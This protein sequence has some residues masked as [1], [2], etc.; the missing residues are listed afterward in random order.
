[1][2]STSKYIQLDQQ[3]LLEY[4]YTDPINPLKI[5]TDNN[6]AKILILNN[7]Y[8][9]SSA[10]F[11]EDLP[12]I[13]TGNYRR[14]SVIPINKDRTKYAYLTD[15]NVVNYLDADNNLESVDG[16]LNQLNTYPNVPKIEPEYD[17]VKLHM[18]SGF[19]FDDLED[20]F[21]FEIL[22]T[23]RAGKKHSLTSLAYMRH[24]E[25]EIANAAPFISNERLFSKYIEL[26]IPSLAW[27]IK[28]WVTDKS[29]TNALGNLI[30]D[31]A[32]FNIQST[33]EISLKYINKT[34]YINGQTYFY[35]GE[36]ITTSINKLDEYSNLTAEII[37]SPI[38]DFFE[39]YGSYN[40]DIYEDF[41]INLNNQPDTDLVVVHDI[42]V[43]EQVGTSW[44]K[45]SEQSFIQTDSY[46]ESYKFRPIILNSHI[47]TSYEI[48]Y[49]LRIL[50]KVD[51]SQ[52]IRKA[53]YN[54][55]DVKKYG[56]KFRKLNLGTVPT[57]TKVYN[58]LQDKSNEIILNNDIQFSVDGNKIIKQTEFVQGFRETI[59]VSASIT[60]VKTENAPKSEDNLDERDSLSIVNTTPS[61]IIYKQGEGKMTISPFDDFT[62][63]IFYDNSLQ[64][65]SGSSS[66]N[67]MDL[68]NTG[69]FYLSF[70]DSE[71]GD[72]VR[73]KNYT[74]VKNISPANGEV[75]FKINKEDSKKILKFKSNDF[76]ISA[77]L[78]VG[79][80]KSD[81]TLMF[82][83][84]WF[85]PQEKYNQISSEII[86]NLKKSNENLR[87]Q[88]KI[89]EES[90][91]EVIREL[92]ADLNTLS[93]EK[94]LLEDRLVELSE[95]VVELTNTVKDNI[96]RKEDK[97]A[98]K[99]EKLGNL[100]NIKLIKDKISQGKGKF[101]SPK[102]FE[103]LK[104]IS[105]KN[106]KINP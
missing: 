93:N 90:S 26:K 39:V 56:R 40:G 85:T 47:A 4:E 53:K 57:V 84:Q 97:K 59:N 7:T 89:E 58:T 95:N 25:Y 43:F 9:N 20:G 94:K 69:S 86:N 18:L 78:E 30:S 66:P 101:V 55:F 45:T 91:N 87:K 34:E 103:N 12:Y 10:I 3:L 64:E 105:I 44:I 51:N 98:Q 77:R 106:L 22:I 100:A 17:I 102:S 60:N 76:Y 8:T 46:E 13:E 62:K 52:I 65:A 14:R 74:N 61:N 82:V 35:P 29:N 32:G 41:I 5:E 2:A 31:N 23:D 24:D 36:S 28:D 15:S 54:S 83:G 6:G 11:T 21:I 19:S 68:T 73:I 80:D 33:I 38:G 70:I 67:L 48:E 49:T 99:N 27:I 104:G 1:M 63:F 92:E 88:L 50:N 42:N 79:Q 96:R 81:E 16:L 71:S 37:E 75:I 72:E